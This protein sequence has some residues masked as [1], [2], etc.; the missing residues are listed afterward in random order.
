MSPSLPPWQLESERER[1][2]RSQQ[3][4]ERSNACS[5][6]GGIWGRWKGSEEAGEEE[7]EEET[8]LESVPRRGSLKA[9]LPASSWAFRHAEGGL[10]SKFCRSRIV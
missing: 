2:S 3:A 9:A 6:L 5:A 8:P 10:G 4:L 1:K 7:E